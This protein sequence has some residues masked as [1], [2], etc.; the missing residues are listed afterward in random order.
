MTKSV[1]M[2]QTSAVWGHVPNL[3]G[4]SGAARTLN[5]SH[6]DKPYQLSELA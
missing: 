4:V 2:P 1:D 6:W 3:Q 5:L